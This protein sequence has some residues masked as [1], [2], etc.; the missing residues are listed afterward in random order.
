MEMSLI[1]FLLEGDN[2][3]THLWQFQE[4]WVL[5]IRLLKIIMVHVM[6]MA[7][8]TDIWIEMVHLLSQ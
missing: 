5:Q 6:E 4:Y 3:R 1:V 7:Q 2:H 8:W